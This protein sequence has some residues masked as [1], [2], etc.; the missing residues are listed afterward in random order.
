MPEQLDRKLYQKVNKI[1]VAAG[2]KWDRKAKAHVFSKDPNEVLG[3][4]VESG[5]ITSKKQ[6]LQQFFTPPE[7]ADELIAYLTWWP[8][9]SVFEPSCG[10]GALLE[11]L[12]R[13]PSAI[14]CSRIDALEIDEDTVQQAIELRRDPNSALRRFAGTLRFSTGDFLS[15]D[16]DEEP[17]Y[18][19]IIMNPPFTRGSDIRHVRHAFNFLSAEGELASIMAPSFQT[20]QTKEAK[21]LR[22]LLDELAYEIYPLPE[23]SFKSSG[24]NVSTVLLVVR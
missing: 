2:G 21:D 4:A 23:G 16:P 5:S 20:S 6:E 3:L 17:Q 24:T 14:E 7:V 12:C 22:S 15:L 8:G 1:L 13:N 11:A 9:L 18:D 19:R 10:H